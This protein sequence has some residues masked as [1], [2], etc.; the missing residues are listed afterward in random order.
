MMT[1]SHR[2]SIAILVSLLFGCTGP[3]SAE[4]PKAEPGPG[5]EAGKAFRPAPPKKLRVLFIGN[6][7]TYSNDLPGV[8][9]ALAKAAGQQLYVESVTYGGYSLE[10]HLTS[11]DALRVLARKK[12][13]YVVLQHGPSTLPESRVELRDSVQKFAPKIRKAGARPALFMVWPP[14]DRRAY[15]DDVREAYSLAASDVNGMF[16]PAG[17]A[18]RAAW[19]RD[20]KAPLYS[21]DQF[22]PSATGTYAAALSIYGMLFR[23]DPLGLPARLNLENGGVIEVPQALA[24][25]LQEAATEANRTYGRP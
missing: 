19:R 17:E 20:P 12:W 14:I 21:A 5:D 24:Q 3:S 16:I 10:D 7:L 4:P 13:N 11:G 2:V 9:Q 18:W 23:R 8:V 22:H 1:R 15:F 25:L 6:S